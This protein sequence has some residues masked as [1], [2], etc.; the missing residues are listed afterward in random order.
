M[1]TEKRKLVLERELKR[2]LNIISSQYKPEK[3]ILF[4][5]LATGRITD[6]SDIDLFIIKDT[7]L[8]YLD[9][10]DEV[11]KLVHTMEAVDIFVVTPKEVEDAQKENNP[12]LQEIFDEGKICYEQ[13]NKRLDKIC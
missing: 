10:V 8:R 9:R 1:N 3:V 4:G 11:R 7:S 5:S 2:I 6:T 13:T 12:Y